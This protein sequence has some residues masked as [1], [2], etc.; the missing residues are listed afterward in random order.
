[1]AQVIKDDEGVNHL[2]GNAS[3]VETLCGATSEKLSPVTE[4]TL[5][6]PQC[7]QIA[8]NA[9][10]LSTKAERKEWRKL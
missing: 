5:T 1:M 10:Q 6:C 9:I 7:A 8:L 2:R 4:G 3:D